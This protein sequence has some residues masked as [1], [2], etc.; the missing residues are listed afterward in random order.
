MHARSFLHSIFVKVWRKPSS[1]GPRGHKKGC[2]AITPLCV[3]SAPTEG[4]GSAHEEGV[5]IRL[6]PWTLTVDELLSLGSIFSISS[7][8]LLQEMGIPSK[9]QRKL[10]VCKYF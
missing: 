4:D 3:I 6:C 9:G 7:V 2:L 8:E 1:W 10:Q 5:C